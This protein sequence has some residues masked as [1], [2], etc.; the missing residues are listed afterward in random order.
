MKLSP[1]NGCIKPQRALT[2]SSDKLANGTG[3]TMGVLLKLYLGNDDAVLE[4]RAAVGAHGI[5]PC[6]VGVDLAAAA[7]LA[8]LGRRHPPSLNVTPCIPKKARRWYSSMHMVSD[9]R[10]Q[11]LRE[12]PLVNFFAYTALMGSLSC[13]L[14]A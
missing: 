10:G 4:H 6:G 1:F 12:A 8:G 7:V 5:A 9:L 2:V 11:D 3:T 14:K 13:R